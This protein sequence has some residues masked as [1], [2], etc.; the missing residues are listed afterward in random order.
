MSEWIDVK[1]EKPPNGA[2]ILI[3]TAGG[4]TFVVRRQG[5]RW[6]RNEEEYKGIPAT[7]WMPLPPP[8]ETK[9]PVTE[10]RDEQISCKNCGLL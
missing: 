10:E 4:A 6:I 3:Y 8:P 1:N 7:H 2:A 9:L 5:R